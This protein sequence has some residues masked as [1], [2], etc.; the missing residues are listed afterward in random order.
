LKFVKENLWLPWTPIIIA[1]ALIV[2]SISCLNKYRLPCSN[3]LFM[4]GLF[5]LCI[6]MVDILLHAHLMAGWFQRQ[7]K[8]ESDEDFKKRKID[9]RKVASEKKNEPIHFKKLS[10]NCTLIGVILILI[11]ITMTI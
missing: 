4:L 6:M 11:A 2:S 3:F 7:R 8:G 5:C 1:V 10:F 9:V